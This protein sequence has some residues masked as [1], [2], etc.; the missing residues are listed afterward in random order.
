MTVRGES[1]RR[2]GASALRPP[3]A[4][5]R[6]ERCLTPMLRRTSDD[7]RLCASCAAGARAVEL[8]SRAEPSIRTQ[9]YSPQAAPSTVHVLDKRRANP[10]AAPAP[11]AGRP[12]RIALLAPPWLRIPPHGYG[13]IESVVALLADALVARGHD[14]TLLAAPGS[15]TDAQ[16]IGLLDS[17][18]PDRIGASVVEADHVARAFE[19]VEREAIAGRPFD[20]LHDHSGWIALAMADRI[21]VPV[22]HTVHG[23]FDED[24]R[25][26]Y[27]AHGNKASIT[28]ISRAQAASRPDGV[29]VDAIVPNPIDVS[30][31]PTDVPKDDHLLWIGRFAPEK[32]AHRAIRVAREA[33]RRLI[34]AG[35][36]QPGQEE[37]FAKEI[38][39]HLDGD[40][41]RYVG[42]VGGRYKQELFASA[43]ALLM[44]ITWPEPFG[45][46]M[47]EAMAA[48]T[49]VI[50]FAEG[51][52]PE[53]VEAGRSGLLVGDEHAMAQAVARAEELD[54]DEC[55]ASARERFSPDRVAARYEEAYRAIATPAPRPR[56]RIEPAADES[57]AVP[58]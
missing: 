37:Y 20:V 22:L 27:A 58:A 9:L 52:A 11:S 15:R 24:A 57:E 48:G 46:V 5:G 12:L 43:R 17:S 10:L 31:W 6:C 50:A 53:V 44:P 54:P 28:C 2:S 25:R 19:H 55:R 56:P 39:P 18:H 4:I 7:E 36:V 41:I 34:L 47:V 35:P 16:T 33:G 38:D 40:R 8:A 30:A 45:M 29:R 26:F 32:G 21:S 13:G 49:P 3:V 14:V 23:S 42:E 51:S 1:R